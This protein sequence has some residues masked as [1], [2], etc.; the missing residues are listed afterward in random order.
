MPATDSEELN[1]I[2]A[3]VENLGGCAKQYWEMDKC[4]DKNNHRWTDCQK[5]VLKLKQCYN[6]LEEKGLRNVQQDR[7][8]QFE[9][10]RLKKIEQERKQ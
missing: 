10:K 6:D 9:I 7:A 5:E 3:I 2:D 1:D 4:L 8:M